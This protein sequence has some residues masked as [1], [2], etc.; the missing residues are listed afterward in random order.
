MKNGIA[1]IILK[2]AFFERTKN[3]NKRRRYIIKIKGM[4]CLREIP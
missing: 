3:M 1:K 4:K 2:T